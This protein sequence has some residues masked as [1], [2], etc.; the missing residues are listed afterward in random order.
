MRHEDD[1]HIGGWLL[2]TL[3]PRLEHADSL[4]RKDRWVGP[5]G[6]L[7][8]HSTLWQ[9]YVVLVGLY[10]FY[11]NI[12]WKSVTWYY[13]ITGAALAFF[14]NNA[15]EGSIGPLPFTL[16]FLSLISLGFS[17]LYLRAARG[18]HDLKSMFEHT[19]FELQLPGRPHVEFAGYFLLLT[20]SLCFVIGVGCG[21]LFVFYVP[22][23]TL[24]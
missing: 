6:T 7:D 3:T 11:L 12:A 22:D 19:A 10:K 24:R 16:V 4:T 17:F 20:G 5:E 9:N 13:L 8:Q 15:G 23:L 14:F 18:L 1:S 2:D 21:V